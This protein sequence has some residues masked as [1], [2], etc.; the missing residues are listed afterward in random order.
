MKTSHLPKV[1]ERKE[2]DPIQRVVGQFTCTGKGNQPPTFG[3]KPCGSLLEISI[4]NIYIT[5]RGNGFDFSVDDCTTFTCP[6]CD[7]ETD[8]IVLPDTVDSSRSLPS[9][10]E[11][12]MKKNAIEEVRSMIE[13]PWCGADGSDPPKRKRP[14][15][16][17]S[18]NLRKVMRKNFKPCSSG[19]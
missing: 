7:Y 16:Y 13:I 3:A 17:L 15:V 9:K 5:E 1:I 4:D 12:M 14:R 11:F 8:I 2:P 10:K 6:V 18:R 19:E